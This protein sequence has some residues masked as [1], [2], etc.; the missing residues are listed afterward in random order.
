MDFFLIPQADGTVLM[1]KPALDVI[2][3]LEIFSYSKTL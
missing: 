2:V 3:D 1:Y